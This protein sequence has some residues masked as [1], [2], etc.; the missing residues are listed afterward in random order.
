MDPITP[1]AVT[2]AD[3]RVHTEREI[4]DTLLHLRLRMMLAADSPMEIGSLLLSGFPSFTAYMRAALRLSGEE[5]GLETPP[6]IE[7]CATIIG[8]DPTPMLACWD[9]RRTLRDIAVPLAA[10][11]TEQYVAF[12]QTLLAYVDGLS[13]TAAG[14]FG[15]G[16]SD[17]SPRYDQRATAT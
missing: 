16:S 17:G 7:R 4:R 8:A 14:Q 5:G 13:Q 12:V 15:T 3:L 9:N 6:V 1:E 10:P 11:L 2:Y